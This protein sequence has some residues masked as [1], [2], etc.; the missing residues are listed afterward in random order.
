MAEPAVAV[1]VGDEGGHDGPGIA[2]V[3][4]GGEDEPVEQPPL[5][6]DER[7]GGGGVDGHAGRVAPEP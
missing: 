6:V 7:V 4:A 1:P 3:A 2:S 5:G